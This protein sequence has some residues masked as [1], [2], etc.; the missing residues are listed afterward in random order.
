V[1]RGCA[2]LT[3]TGHEVIEAS[4]PGWIGRYSKNRARSS[5]KRISVI[6]GHER[7]IS[8]NDGQEPYAVSRKRNAP[9]VKRISG[10]GQKINEIEEFLISS[11]IGRH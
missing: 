2:V 1:A 6:S 5:T 10:F 8:R 7:G 9:A 3:A 11:V 4:Q